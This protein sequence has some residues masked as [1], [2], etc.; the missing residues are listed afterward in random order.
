MDNK[1]R[2]RRNALIDVLFDQIEA[3]PNTPD[4]MRAAS[5]VMA[6]QSAKRLEFLGLG[7]MEAMSRYRTA[8]E[9]LKGLGLEVGGM[10]EPYQ[11]DDHV[12]G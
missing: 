9:T 12:Q 6:W 1:E 5:A 2:E 8:Y 10:I 7:P 4:A 3:M 11:G